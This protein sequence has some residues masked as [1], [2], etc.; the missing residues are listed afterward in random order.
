M[1]TLS[2]FFGGLAPLL[3][4]IGLYGIMFSRASSIVLEEV[5]ILI[6]AGLAIG[7]ASM[8]GTTPF[9]ESFLYGIKEKVRCNFRSLRRYYP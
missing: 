4:M 9:V 8:L 6:A 3:T 7:L 1:P 2:G 5:A